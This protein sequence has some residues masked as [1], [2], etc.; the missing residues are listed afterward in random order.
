MRHVRDGE[1]VIVH[2][3]RASDDVVLITKLNKP[4]STLARGLAD[5]SIVPPNMRLD[6]PFRT[7]N[8]DAERSRAALAEFEAERES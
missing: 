4:W 8:V 5:G 3:E 1:D 7:T 6:M 2:S